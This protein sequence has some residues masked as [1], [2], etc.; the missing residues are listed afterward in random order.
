M[1]HTPDRYGI[2][3]GNG[4]IKMT[5]KYFSTHGMMTGTVRNVEFLFDTGAVFVL[6][7]LSLK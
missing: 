4:M 2:I 7:D 5:N 6:S 3:A 1:T